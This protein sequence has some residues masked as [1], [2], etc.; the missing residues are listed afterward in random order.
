MSDSPWT[1]PDTVRGFVQSPPNQTLLRFAAEIR[2]RHGGTP[3]ALDIGCG[4]ARNAMP[5]AAAG[6]DVF[7]VDTSWPMI[8]AAYQRKMAEQATRLHLARTTMTHLPFADHTFDLVIA[9]GVW[10]LSRADQEFRQAITDAAR[11]ARPG[12]AMFVF[13]FSRQ[14]LSADARP[15]AGHTYV[16]DQFS[17]QPQVFLSAEQLLAELRAVGFEPDPAVPLTEH[18]RAARAAMASTAPVIWE[19]AF[20]RT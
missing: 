19:A 4:A 14:T 6:W 10:N 3:R 11:V 16:Y 2:A 12:G 15:V 1:R 17:G 13:T 8:A 18:K 9:H 20:H 5:L 7:G